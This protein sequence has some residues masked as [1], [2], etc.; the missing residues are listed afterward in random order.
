MVYLSNLKARQQ[1][2]GVL[3]L[4]RAH[5]V[6]R[7]PQA[8]QFVHC[9]FN[10]LKREVRAEQNVIGQRKLHHR[11]HGVG[12]AGMRD[13]EIELLQLGDHSVGNVFLRAWDLS[14]NG[15]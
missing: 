3:A 2:F 1:F 7:K 8:R 6:R 13:V 10:R 4:D 9:R 11:G 12:I 5:D 15:P 14:D